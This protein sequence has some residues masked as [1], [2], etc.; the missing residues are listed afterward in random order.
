MTFSLVVPTVGRASLQRLFASLAACE[1]P[2]PSEIVLVDDRPGAGPALDAGLY[3]VP[4]WTA[5]LIRTLTSA[6]RGPATARNV[7]WRSVGTEW[8]AFLD[9]DV[10]VTRNWLRDLEHDLATAGADAGASQ[11]QLS[12]PLPA[13][14]RPTDWERGTHG[15]STAR[16]ITADMA[17]RLAALRAVGGFDERFPRA[18]REDAD[19]ALRVTQAGYRITDGDRHTVHP[20]RSAPWHAS[21]A[22]QRGNA[23]DALMRKVHGR[24]WHERAGAHVGRRPRHLVATAAGV[25]TLAGAA[26]GRRS[27]ALPAGLTWAAMTG[28]FAR[29]R[30]AP[31]PG[32]AGERATM[33]TTSILIP[34]VASWQWL[35]GLVRHRN[36][37]RWP[38]G[39][40]SIQAVLLDRDGTMV[41]DVPYNGIPQLVEPLPGVGGALGRL[42]AAGIRV[43]VV[44]NQSGVARGLLTM[45]QVSAVNS[46]VE[47]L[48]GPFGDWQVCPHDA[49][50]GCSCRKPQPGMV[51]AAAQALGVAVERCAVIGDT[52]SDVQAATSAGAGLAALVPNDVT[53]QE[54]IDAAP[55]VFETFAEA[56]DAILA[57]TPS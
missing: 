31:G 40:T 28:E 8:V 11:A 3:S 47:E 20:V 5:G 15:L 26:T 17:Y 4:G 13:H 9:D 44:T 41:R 2:R 22:Q 19:L 39:R 23:D 49:E 30:I 57:R 7:G 32:T 37:E 56:V 48:L 1:G 24:D 50:D 42:R 46:R 25:L 10:E 43:G 16:W 53:R 18:F 21:V 14:R 55:A 36:A 52:G 45:A 6:G 29:A 51:L 33:V 38:A 54:E 27:I 35:R 12:V 34:P